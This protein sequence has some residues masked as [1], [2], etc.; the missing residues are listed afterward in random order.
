MCGDS[1]ALIFLLFLFA[2]LLALFE[3]RLH[4]QAPRSEA[5]NKIQFSP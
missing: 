2:A 5:Y 4:L 1:F 3:A